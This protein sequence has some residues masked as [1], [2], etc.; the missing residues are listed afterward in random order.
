MA[1][2]G[3]YAAAPGEHVLQ[4]SIVSSMFPHL[5]NGSQG[6]FRIGLGLVLAA[7]IVLSVLRLPLPMVIVA[8]FAPLLL[9]VIYLVET[10]VFAD[11]PRWVW[12]LTFVLGTAVGVGWALLT[13]T[14]VAESYSLG[15]GTE[16]PTARLVRDALVIPFGGLVAMQLPTV[17]IRLTRPPVRESLYGFAIG[18][19]GATTFVLAVNMV[20]LIPQ[21]PGAM[22]PADQPV[23]D[24]LLEAGVRGVTMPLTAAAVGGLFGVGLWFPRRGG[25]DRRGLAVASALSL[26]MAGALYATVGL[27]D[28]FRV[29]PNIQFLIHIALALASVVALRIGLQLGMLREHHE[30]IRPDLPILCPDCGHVVPDMA[31]CPAC[32]VAAHAA[33]A[34]SRAARRL[35]RPQPDEQAVDQ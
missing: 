30:E 24:L 21:L 26:L 25:T 16:V 23:A 32:G 20:R 13:T 15:L 8:A 14:I 19:L 11:L 33:S 27:V 34:T 5:P 3:D 29:V 18:A 7:L 4:P 10:G 31:F 28:V 12:A 2:V 22:G 9:F 17:L 1:A 35:N 6:P